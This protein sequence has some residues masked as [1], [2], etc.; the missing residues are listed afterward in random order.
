[1]TNSNELVASESSPARRL[2]VLVIDDDPL[3]RS[4]LVSML[5]RDYQVAVAGEGAEGF[6]KA[7]EEPPDLAIIDIQMPGW[8]GLTTLTAFRTHP[9]LARVRVVVLTSDASKETILA[10][11]SKGAEDYVIKTR[12][13]RREFLEKLERMAQLLDTPN[14]PAEVASPSPVRVDESTPTFPEPA[15]ATLDG[16]NDLVR[17]K[18][19]RDVIESWE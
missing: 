11:V 7:L 15:F 19:L 16:S 9:H 4:L 5:R 8:D 1:M 14:P 3:F 2:R 13:S 18:A 10:A 6:Y 12:F 17:A